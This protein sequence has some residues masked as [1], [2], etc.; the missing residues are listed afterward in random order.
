VVVDRLAVGDRQQPA[1]QVVGV[2][3]P[4]VGAER[5]QE[6]LLEAVLGVGAADGAAQ[7]RHHDPG[8]LADQC[9]ERGE[10]FHL[11]D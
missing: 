7:G 1:A 11:T 3:E 5:R 8:V 10:S 6:C 9:L 2:A 4:W